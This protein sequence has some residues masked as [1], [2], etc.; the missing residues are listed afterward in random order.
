MDEDAFNMSLRKFLKKVGVTSQREI[1]QAVRAAHENGSLS[2]K[3][4]VQAKVTLKIEAVGLSHDID[5]EINI[6]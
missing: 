1:E 6:S 4:S 2:G 5:G 3:S